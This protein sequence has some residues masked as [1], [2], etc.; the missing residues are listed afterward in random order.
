MIGNIAAATVL[1]V[2]L[3]VSLTDRPPPPKP[4]ISYEGHVKQDSSA[5][6]GA[7]G[8]TDNPSPGLYVT[9]TTGA[10][11]KPSLGIYQHQ[12]RDL[13]LQRDIIYLSVLRS[14]KADA[15]ASISADLYQLESIANPQLASQPISERHAAVLAKQL[16][17][18]KDRLDAVEK[19]LELE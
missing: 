8:A 10:T 1:I 18:I 5:I 3:I 15:M 4:P 16:Q 7:T 17:D 11:E 13:R 9:G 14:G 19:D 2:L 12:L 6:T